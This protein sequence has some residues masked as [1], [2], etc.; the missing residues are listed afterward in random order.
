MLLSSNSP[1]GM[2]KKT[3]QI[4]ATHNVK[5]YIDKAGNPES[6]K[7]HRSEEHSQPDSTKAQAT[8]ANA[9]LEQKA[10]SKY[11][12]NKHNVKNNQALDVQERLRTDIK[13]QASVLIWCIRGNEDV[14]QL[15]QALLNDDPPPIREFHPETIHRDLKS[16][17]PS[18]AVFILHPNDNLQEVQSWL[19]KT[20]K[21]NEEREILSIAI[22]KRLNLHKP[23]TE[24]QITVLNYIRNGCTNKQIADYMEVRPRT[25]KEWIKDLFLI[26]DACGR[27]EL[28]ARFDEVN[29]DLGTQIHNNNYY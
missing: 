19:N 17:R 18:M 23:L 5:K 16:L 4:P 12:T 27:V 3:S 9:K 15:K 14:R 29:S 7:T 22:S 13:P 8:H 24:R 25:V 2:I 11:Y 21:K 26:F 10:S 28:V 6:E 20:F 1:T